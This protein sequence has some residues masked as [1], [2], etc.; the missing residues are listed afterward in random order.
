MEWQVKPINRTCAA[1]G[2]ELVPGDL[3]T[4][5]VH[6]P[7][8]GMMERADVLREHAAA[9]KPAGLLLGRWNRE[10]KERGE[11]ERAQRAQLLASR[12]EFFLSLYEDPSDPTGEKAILKHLLALLLERRRLIKATGPAEGGLTPY[13]HVRT[14]QVLP[15]PAIDLQPEDIQRVQGTLDLLIG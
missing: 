4:C 12:E 1:T 5:V 2:R 10:V 14:Q 3:V 9:F 7:V 13:L 11:E 8:G 6:K 15:V